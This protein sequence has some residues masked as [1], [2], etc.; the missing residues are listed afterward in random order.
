MLN[1]LQQ[2][3]EQQ[4]INWRSQLRA[5][6]GELENLK[7]NT[8]R[9]LQKDVTSLEIELASEREERHLLQQQLESLK[10]SSSRQNDSTATIERLSEVVIIKIKFYYL[11]LFV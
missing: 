7:A 9:K 2:H 3:V 1:K 8:L 10:S 11:F 4:E 6:D 5:K